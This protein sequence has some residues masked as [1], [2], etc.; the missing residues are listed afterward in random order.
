[1]GT[2]I[3]ST[4]RTAHAAADGGAGTVVA[5]IELGDSRLADVV[6]GGLSQVEELLVSELSAGEDFLTEAALH[7]ARAGG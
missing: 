1:M 5:G 6:R 3:V 7:L 4:E 2:D